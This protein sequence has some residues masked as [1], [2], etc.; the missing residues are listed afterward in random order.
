MENAGRAAALVIHERLAPGSRVSCL[1][2]TGNNGGDGFVVARQLLRLGHRVRVLLCG[3]EESLAADARV[4]F[5]A[6]VGLGGDVQ[7][8]PPGSD[9]KSC[10]VFFSDVDA[11]VDGLL[12]TGLSRELEG[13]FR[14]VVESL[15]HSRHQPSRGRHSSL[16]VFA[17]DIP[18]GLSGDTGAVLGVAV[19]A[20][21]TI[22]FGHPKLGLLTSGAPDHCGELVIADLG[23]PQELGPACQP[24]AYWV[25]RKDVARLLP[26]RAVSTH[27][28]RSGR[29]LVVAGSVGKTGAAL[30]AST[31]ALRAGGGLVT[32]CTFPEAAQSL[33]QRVVEVMTRSIDP[34]RIAASLDEA[35]DG[36]DVVVLGPGL[37][38]SEAARSV[39]E[40]IVF[41]WDGPKVL[42]ADAITLVSPRASELTRASGR[43]LLTPHPGELGRLLQLSAAEVE[44]QRHALLERAVT[45]TGQTVL[46]KGP[47]TLIGAPGATPWVT[48][49][50]H[51]ALATGGSGDVLSGVCGALAVS[52][53]LLQAGAAAAFVHG[54]AARLWV[55]AH[56]G[57]DRGLLAR[58]IADFLPE[59][60]AGLR[61]AA[62]SGA[63]SSGAAP[64]PC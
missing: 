3:K 51:P 22:T 42:D 28:G 10:E 19:R 41:G 26:A 37:G 17:L 64:T 39:V 8:L 33:E 25:E 15:E 53:P 5:D 27:K 11:V 62:S 43:C 14:A 60:L 35:L 23:V 57:A 24:S 31:A 47:H 56:A 45:L 52:L 49:T 61:G 55:E 30:L 20:D 46:L 6:W 34:E 44:A 58:E 1:C 32:I 38:L 12:G 13:S 59:A 48:S 54:E 2:G 40:H 9:A 16:Q 7:G 50:G 36:V 18:S 4:N 29:V 63:A 21:V